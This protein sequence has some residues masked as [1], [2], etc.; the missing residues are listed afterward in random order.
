[1]KSRV[2]PSRR[3]C[4]APKFYSAKACGRLGC[5]DRS[6]GEQMHLGKR[7]RRKGG[8]K[9]KEGWGWGVLYSPVQVAWETS[10]RNKSVSEGRRLLEGKEDEWGESS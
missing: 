10:L 9:G 7:G 3:H 4:G 5:E 2:I 6:P 1:M 8:R